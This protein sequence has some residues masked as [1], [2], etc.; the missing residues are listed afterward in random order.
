MKNYFFQ[1]NYNLSK[2]VCFSF[3]D[4]FACFIIWSAPFASTEVKSPFE[5]KGYKKEGTTDFLF[6]LLCWKRYNKF[7]F[8][9]VLRKKKEKKK[10]E[11]NL[12]SL[13]FLST[14]RGWIFPWTLSRKLITWI[15]CVTLTILA[16]TSKKIDKYFL[17]AKSNL[18]ENSFTHLRHFQTFLL[19]AYFYK[20]ITWHLG[21]VNKKVNTERVSNWI[22]A[23]SSWSG[24][25]SFDVLPCSLPK[26]TEKLLL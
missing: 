25:T 15:K 13:L 21:K 4:C 9:V 19:F 12:D 7:C 8:S 2:N 20:K 14:L 26:T 3:S 10:E 23:Q 1:K 24:F 22:D 16:K 17:F 6:L 5:N 18:R 11:E